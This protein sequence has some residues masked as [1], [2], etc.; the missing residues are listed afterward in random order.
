M[1][2][3]LPHGG[4]AELREPRDLKVKDKVAVQRAITWEQSAGDP[5]ETEPSR[6]IIPVNAG[7]P[8]DLHMA[9]LGR[10]IVSW[11]LDGH[12]QAPVPATTDVLDNLEIDVYEALCT[13][14]EP[15]MAV[16]RSRPNSKTPT[17]SSGG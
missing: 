9:M 4:W 6:T 13:A 16:V 11:S 5:N 15:H 8:D 12:S 7:L 3:D 10:V 2:I 14:I 1:R 17:A